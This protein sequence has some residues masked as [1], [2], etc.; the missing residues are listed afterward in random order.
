MKNRSVGQNVDGWCTKCKMVLAHTIEALV[1]ERITRVHC[2]TCGAPHAWRASAPGT[3]TRAPR[4]GKSGTAARRPAARAVD[5][6][7]TYDALVGSRR[8]DGARAYSVR[9]SFRPNELLAH[10]TFGVGVVTAERG[11][12]I[13]VLFREGPRT[14][15]QRRD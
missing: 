13:D 12:K 10:P 5:P 4:S 7:A 6:A 11:D 9:D 15:A 8:V 1:G 2:N 14:L 3:T